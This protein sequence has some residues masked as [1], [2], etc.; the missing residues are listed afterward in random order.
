MNRI[1]TR[2]Y[3]SFQDP[4]SPCSL[5]GGDSGG[6]DTQNRKTIL[7]CHK[8]FSLIELIVSLVIVGIM[9]AVVYAYMGSSL[10]NSV[11]PVVWLNDAQTANSVM[12]QIKADYDEEFPSHAGSID[13]WIESFFDNVIKT[14]SYASEV[15]SIETEL[16]KFT[17]NENSSE[18]E[19]E[20]PCTENCNYLRVTVTKGLQKVIAVFSE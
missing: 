18:W 16:S 3:N 15:D 9:S 10:T 2:H 8:G 6:S 19:W 20:D 7:R 12:E 1:N 17:F 4:I 11:F 13:P 14:S 5:T